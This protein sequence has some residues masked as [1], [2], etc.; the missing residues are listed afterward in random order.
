MKIAFVQDWLNGFAGGEQ[1]L[2]ALHELYPDA[3]IYTSVYNKEKTPQFNKAK[4]IPSYLQ[5]FSYLRSHHQIAIPLMPLA[6]ESFDLKEYDVIVS[7]GGGL[8]KG[9]ITQPGQKHITYCNTPMRYLWHIGGDTRS[10]G[11]IRSR[12]SH[13]LRIW[14]VVSASRVDQFVAN[15]QTVADRIAK[16]YRMSA[17]VIFPPV[18]TDRFL[19]SNTDPGDY[20]LSVGRLISYKRV[21][22]AVKAA[23]VAKLPLKVVGTGPEEAALKELAKDAPW[24]EFLGRVSDEDLQKLYA[25]TKGF[26]FGAEEDFGIVPV[27]AMSAGRPIIAFGKGGATETVVQGKTGLFFSEQTTESLVETLLDFKNYTWNSAKIRAHAKE[28]D[29][30]VFQEKMKELIES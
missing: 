10:D 5:K 7:I 13:T 29:K 26:I 18:T 12:V 27:E 1:V 24:I 8:A 23:K 3:P 11:F 2:L 25:E 19:P 9:V 6:F 28:F 21:D 4:V 17:K 14:D 20:F 15:S 30:K 16:F 22:L